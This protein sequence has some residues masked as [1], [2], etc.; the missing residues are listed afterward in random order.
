M[1]T[2]QDL[3]QIHKLSLVA[4]RVYKEKLKNATQ[5]SAGQHLEEFSLAEIA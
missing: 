2:D 5:Y 3:S 1:G 4:K